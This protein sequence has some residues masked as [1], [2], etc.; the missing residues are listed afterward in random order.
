MVTAKN[1]ISSI[2][3]KTIIQTGTRHA[4]LKEIL[5]KLDC[6]VRG[7]VILFNTFKNLTLRAHFH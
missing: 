2:E 1:S 6:R 5:L 3:I 4:V 7:K